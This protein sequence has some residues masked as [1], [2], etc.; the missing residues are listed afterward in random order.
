MR[1]VGLKDE[2]KYQASHHNTGEVPSPSRSDCFRGSSIS[3]LDQ[4]YRIQFLAWAK[5]AS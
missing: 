4:M 2:L 1:I 5:I 3:V